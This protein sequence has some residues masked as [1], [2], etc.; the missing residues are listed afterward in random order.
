MRALAILLLLSAGTVL[1]QPRV[2]FPWWEG[3]FSQDL[4]LSGDQR[5]EIRKI[6]Q[7]YRDSMID[8]R[9]ATE[10]AEARLEDL[11]HDDEIPTAASKSAVDALVDAR[12]AMTRSLTEMSIELRQ[13][14]TTDQWASLER[15]RRQMRSRMM[16]DRGGR[17]RPRRPGLSGHEGRGPDGPPPRPEEHH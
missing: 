3:R 13:V 12:G 17:G 11:F 7:K 8:Q 1:A 14:L 6:Q 10:K 5:A 4:D 2:Y 9:A 16:R 15:K